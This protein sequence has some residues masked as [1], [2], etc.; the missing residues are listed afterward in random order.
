MAS[1]IENVIQVDECRFTVMEMRWS[2][3]A[4]SP[5]ALQAVACRASAIAYPRDRGYEWGG[6]IFKS[7]RKSL[8]RI[9]NLWTVILPVRRT[10]F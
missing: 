1:V 10:V 9:S 8:P 7:P 5:Q 3:V 2:A 4:W 6:Y